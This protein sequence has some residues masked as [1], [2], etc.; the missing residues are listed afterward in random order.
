MPARTPL[1][2]ALIARTLHAYAHWLESHALP[3]HHARPETCP[4]LG[5]L[6]S[7]PKCATMLADQEA[8]GPRSEQIM[9]NITT[10]TCTQCGEDF[11]GGFVAH[12]IK[13]HPRTVKTPRVVE[14][15]EAVVAKGFLAQGYHSERTSPV[16]SAAKPQVKTTRVVTTPKPSAKSERTDRRNAV[17][18]RERKLRTELRQARSAMRKLHARLGPCE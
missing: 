1:R 18:A 10:S 11:T 15:A 4:D 17:P 14:V 8:P 5:C 7:W 13:T 9:K 2:R 16:R 3:A 6:T 12:K